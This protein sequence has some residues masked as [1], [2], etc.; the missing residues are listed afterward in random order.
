[1]LC[2]GNHTEFIFFLHSKHHFRLSY[3][4]HLLEGF[5]ALLKE[6]FGKGA[7]HQVQGD[8]QEYGKVEKPAYYIHVTEKPKE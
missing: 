1:M 4:P 5:T 3:Y 2:I 6:V 7:K 8:F